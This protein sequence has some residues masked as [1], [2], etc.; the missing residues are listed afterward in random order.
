MRFQ[1]LTG[2][3]A[4]ISG[5]QPKEKIPLISARLGPYSIVNVQEDFNYNDL[6]YGSDKHPHRTKPTGGVPIGS[7]LNTLSDFPFVDHRRE[8]WKACWFNTGDCL[9]AKGFSAV[10][11]ELSAGV[12]V[13]IYNLHAE[14]GDDTL[15][16]KARTTGFK[17][18]IEFMEEYSA[19]NAII[20]AGDTNTRY[21][22]S[23]DPIRLLTESG[24][25]LTDVWVEREKDGKPP[26]HGNSIECRF[27]VPAGAEDNKCEQ[28]DK[29]LYRSSPMLK[30]IPT[31]Y[32]NENAKFLTADGGPL[33]DHFPMAVPFDWMLAD[34]LR[35][36]PV[37]GGQQ[38]AYYNDLADYK[39]KAVITEISFRGGSRLDKMEY[40]LSDGRTIRHGGEGGGQT[41]TM[42]LAGDE[43][44][45]S[46]EFCEEKRSG[47]EM[48]VFF[49]GMRS[50]KGQW[51]EGG[52]RAGRCE[53]YRAEDGFTLAGF[54]GRKGKEIDLVGA[55][56]GK[57]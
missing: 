3:V 42:K 10:R 1:G 15:D 32:L 12:F 34:N 51:I 17:Q 37:F 30:L 6:T 22:S 40:K 23:Q 5:G 11:V 24:P 45:V 26:G 29:I 33:S 36:T 44:I 2:A 27:P 41:Y 4:I 16:F 43:T 25:R 56:W 49:I 9:T 50:S 47:G 14:A 20:L 35:S 13:D 55:Y 39:E 21:T 46:V 8:T 57:K 53:T 19:G 7:G 18:M 54:W 38:G 52:K 48:G 28:I 31:G